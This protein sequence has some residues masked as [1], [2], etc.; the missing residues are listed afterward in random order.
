MG[1]ILEYK[2]PCCCGPL[3][4]DTD[5]QKMKCPYC[6]NE[7]DAETLKAND[8]ILKEEKP[9]MMD[10]SSQPGNE[11][12]QG[13]LDGQ[14]VY[15]CKSCG[16]QIICDDTTGATDCPYC[17]SP[18]VLVGQFAGDKRPDLIIPF[19][20]DKEAAKAGFKQHLQKKR[21]L[22]KQFRKDSYIDEIKGVYV[23]FWLFGAE[24]DAQA[25]YHATKV[26]CWS[27]S[28][29]NYTKTSHFRLFRSGSLSFDRVPVDGSSKMADDLMESI[30]PY[31]AKDE[32]PFQTAYLSGYIADKY[33]VDSDASIGRA[34][35][36]IKKSTLDQMATTATG[37]T[38]VTPENASVQ[39]KNSSVRYALYPVWLLTAKWNG[40]IYNFAMNGQTGKFVGNLPIDKGAY[41]RWTG[42]IALIA[43]I[44]AFGVSWFLFLN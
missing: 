20:L 7:F 22:P 13:E 36:R 18:V 40:E 1:A 29:Y 8:D 35:D 44:I 14:K 4:F 23:P 37:Y 15:L 19:K 41:W 31:Y 30:E 21:L 24:A 26:T 39:F 16:G 33:D 27:D 17:G 25:Y 6:D 11:W 12:M 10:W 38:T 2:C 9:D 28:D 34:N 5:S 42:L 43:T 3:Q 32:V